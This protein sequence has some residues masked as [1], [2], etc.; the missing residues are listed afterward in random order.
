MAASPARSKASE[1]IRAGNTLASLHVCDPCARH[2][3]LVM[4]KS[5][6]TACQK[7]SYSS[8]RSGL[9]LCSSSLWCR[10]V[11]GRR[12]HAASGASGSRSGLIVSGA[13]MAGAIS[14]ASSLRQPHLSRATSGRAA[15]N[16]GVALRAHARRCGDYRDDRLCVA[17]HS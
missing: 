15:S 12:S 10:C 16:A 2:L 8:M 6:R 3:G 17:N 14:T 4:L 7:A 9:Y 11:V 13:R 1:G 5:Q